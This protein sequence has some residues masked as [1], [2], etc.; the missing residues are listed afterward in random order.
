MSEELEID[1]TNYKEIIS[2]D[3]SCDS[4]KISNEA[5]LVMDEQSFI[6]YWRTVEGTEH[7]ESLTI[8]YNSS[9]KDVRLLS[10]FPNV[11]YLILYS[12][13]LTS[14]EG[15]EWFAKG[16]Y[17]NIQ[18]YKN[19]RRSITLL[20]QSQVD[21]INIDVERPEDLSAIAECR[22]LTA[23]GLAK[24]MQLDLTTW[25]KVP[26]DTITFRRGKFKDLGETASITSLNDIRVLGCRS[27]E[28]FVGDNSRITRLIAVNCKKLDL[29]TISTFEGI[30]V[31][32]VN[33]CT[34]EMNLTEIGGLIHV[35]H[36][37]FILCNVQVDLIDLKEYFPSLE[38]LHISKMKKEF[39]L[40][41]KQL[42]PDVR[43]S[44]NSF[45][46]E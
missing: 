23:L 11:K 6:E 4:L 41:L 33:S 20:P 22:H 38:S 44:G 29:R 12:R 35:K 17:I 9:L 15:I 36:I 24:S 16:E 21:R 26:L 27:L 8:N 2:I 3:E 28:R 18:T 7:I 14:L 34:N 46:I 31:L 42:N 19:R 1:E 45:E 25:S 37:D 43:I 5:E 30:E 39:G 40:Q 13:R 32:I 10:A